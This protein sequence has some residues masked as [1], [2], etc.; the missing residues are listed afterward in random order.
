MGALIGPL[1]PLGAP[2]TTT[3]RGSWG[4][5]GP[6]TPPLTPSPHRSQLTPVATHHQEQD[7]AQA[8]IQPSTTHNGGYVNFGEWHTV[9]HLDYILKEQLN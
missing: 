5:L 8:R 9:A 4:P 7:E 6:H 3:A 2:T 1:G